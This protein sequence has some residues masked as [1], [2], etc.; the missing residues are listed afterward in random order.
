MGE[1]AERFKWK[2]NALTQGRNETKLVVWKG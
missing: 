2:E 1:G